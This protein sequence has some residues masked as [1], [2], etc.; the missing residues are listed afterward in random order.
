MSLGLAGKA[1]LRAR[2]AIDLVAGRRDPLV[3]PHRL[4]AHGGDFVAVGDELLSRLVPLAKLRPDDRVLE[5]G[6]G[7]G[8]LARPLAD[9][10]GPGGSYDGLGT[11]PEALAW[12]RYAYRDRPD[13]AFT[14]VEAEERH[15]LAGAAGDV[16][17]VR[18]PFADGAFD[19]VIAAGVV[20][21]LAEDRIRILLGEARRV[22]AVDGRLFATA[23]LL[24][25]V[26]R[27]A[28][29]E[30]SAQPHFAETGG[31]GAGCEPPSAQIG[32]AH[33]E[34]WL[35]DRVAEAG[36]R[37]AGIRHGTWVPRDGGLGPQDALVARR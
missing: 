14:L 22:L 18:L 21:R 33:D 23:Y 16:P 30:G 5:V 19:L 29:A 10:L 13:F 1:K 35:L 7:A 12:C 3:P 6:C 37:T 25:D 8:R 11:G 27:G 4:R 31:G 28:I 26:A 2:D 17:N 32:V 34:E 9:C 36:F 24:D 15:P 20:E